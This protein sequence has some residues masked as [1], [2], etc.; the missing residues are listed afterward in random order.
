MPGQLDSEPRQSEQRQ[1]ALASRTRRR[2]LAVLEESPLP[3]DAAAIAE[4]FGIHVTTARFHLEQLEDA[5]LVE[6]IVQRAGQRGRPRVLFRAAPDAHTED[7]LRQLNSVLVDALA[8]DSDG[9]RSRARDAGERWS[10]AFAD[11]ADAGTDD[12]DPLLRIFH[13]LG[14]EPEERSERTESAQRREHPES[15]ERVI[16]LRSC[17]F[18]DAATE[19]PEVVCSAHRGLLDGTVERLGHDVGEA[20]LLPFVEPELCLVQLRGSLAAG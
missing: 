9:G 1:G 12:A 20:T 14:F 5:S 10:H 15:A 19:H 16:E 8:H 2:V 4:R 18:R 7:A 17:P 13:R 3:L 11:Q 6:R